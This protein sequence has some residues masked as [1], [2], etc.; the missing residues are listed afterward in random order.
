MTHSVQ[1]R[2][3]SGATSTSADLSLLE[4][5]RALKS[6]AG[7][8]KAG[9]RASGRASKAGESS[10]DGVDPAP[11][12]AAPP[13]PPAPPAASAAAPLGTASLPAFPAPGARRRSPRGAANGAKAAQ[14]DS[15]R[16]CGD[17]VALT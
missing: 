10:H 12:A 14:R 8:S 6:K 1:Q 13:A 5:R 3:T 2:F 11:Y 4:A 16:L 15:P 7:E 17:A 9:E